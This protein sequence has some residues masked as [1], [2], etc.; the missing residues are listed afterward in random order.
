MR[1]LREHR[2]RDRDL[3]ARVLRRT[4]RGTCSLLFVVALALGLLPSPVS[5]DASDGSILF[6]RYD[7]DSNTFSLYA[8]RTDGSEERRLTDASLS[9]W[10]ATFSPD[11]SHLVFSGARQGD[12]AIYVMAADGTSLRKLTE[13]SVDLEPGW[14]PDGARIVFVR[15]DSLI[16]EQSAVMT[17]LADGSEERAVT[18]ATH[19]HTDPSWSPDGTSILFTRLRSARR[20]WDV[21]VADAEGS[22]I[23][24]LTA[25]EGNDLAPEWSPTGDRIVYERHCA[26][27]RG[28]D[29]SEI[30][31]MSPDGSGKERMMFNRSGDH[32]PHWSP[33]GAWISFLRCSGTSCG[34]YVMKAT[35]RDKIE[36]GSGDQGG[37]P[38][39]W[40]PDS[41]ALSYSQTSE[42]GYTLFTI[43]LTGAKRRIGDATGV[44]VSDW[45]Q[46]G[47]YSTGAPS[48][49]LRRRTLDHSRPCRV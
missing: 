32:L 5:A 16:D 45:T 44:A 6:S 15:R 21:Y 2:N 26:C 34:I 1:R 35:G 20:G 30:Y 39:V 19:S 36:L 27:R 49:Q 29:S 7:P 13:G 24:N 3:G 22:S 14:S 41:S 43:D 4:R 37:T 11:G 33:D 25:R 12:T 31:A 8:T 42:R 23:R 9:A 18:A 38:Y 48:S 40:A 17:M 46:T 28:A 10:D 47:T